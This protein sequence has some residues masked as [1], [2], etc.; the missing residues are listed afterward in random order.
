MTDG[1]TDARNDNSRRPILAS[2]NNHSTGG[3][4]TRLAAVT[5]DNMAD[6]AVAASVSV[7]EDRGVWTPYP[8]SSTPLPLPIFF[9]PTLYPLFSPILFS[10]TPA[11]NSNFLPPPPPR[12]PDT[13]PFFVK[14]PLPPNPRAPAPPPPC[15]PPRKFTADSHRVTSF[16]RPS[17]CELIIIAMGHIDA[18]RSMN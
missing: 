6:G 11:Q 15:P 4:R 7:R 10:G 18:G 3:H 17:F 14:A 5:L 2:G 9:L 12:P 1:Q 16:L 13:R 8:Q